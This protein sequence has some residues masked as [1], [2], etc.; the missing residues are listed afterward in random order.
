[1]NDT[2]IET[3]QTYLDILGQWA[4]QKALKINPSEGKAV[5]FTRARVKDPLNNIW[6][7][8]EFQKR[9]AANI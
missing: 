6:W 3:L 7:T 1:M 8:K 5:S 2:Y 4:V 9:A